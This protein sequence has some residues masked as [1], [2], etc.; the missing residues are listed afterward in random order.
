MLVVYEV[1]PVNGR[2]IETRIDAFFFREL[3]VFWPAPQ[4]L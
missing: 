4:H 3:L 2:E 1:L